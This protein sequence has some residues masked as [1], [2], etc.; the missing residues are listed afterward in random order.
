MENLQVGTYGWQYESWQGGFYPEDMP[1]DWWLDF[2]ANNYRVVLVP[3]TL[4]LGW[5]EDD[6]EEALDAVEG[7][8]SF[9]FEVQES[10]DESKVQQLE[11]IAEIFAERAAGVV[12]FSEQNNIPEKVAELP[13]TLV[14]K[15]EQLNGWSWKHQEWI[16][17][18]AECGVVA[19][20]NIEPKQQTE[21]LKDF[22]AGLP[23]G[24]QGAPFIV[25]DQNLDMKQLFSL[26][27][28]GEFL[29]Y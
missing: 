14:S 1:E 27:T 16:C 13:V 20:I 21:L 25:Y 2:Y 18:G 10:L 3:E 6:F 5:Q 12:V 29:G 22:M 26:K 7:A 23:E 8:F 28:I 24:M 17:S 15:T 19:S 11:S 9:Y 4:W